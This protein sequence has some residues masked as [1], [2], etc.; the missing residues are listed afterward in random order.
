VSTINFVIPRFLRG[1]PRFFALLSG[2]FATVSSHGIF[3]KFGIAK[4]CFTLLL[5]H[6]FGLSRCWYFVRCTVARVYEEFVLCSMASLFFRLCSL[7]VRL[8]SCLACGSIPWRPWDLRFPNNMSVFLL[9]DCPF[10]LDEKSPPRV[11]PDRPPPPTAKY[12]F[13]KKVSPSPPT[14]DLRRISPGEH[15][16]NPFCQGTPVR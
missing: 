5:L 15:F 12:V 8:D 11:K 14:K 10:Y 9:G 4:M 3:C 16:P 13:W 7:V 6:F 2:A 1:P